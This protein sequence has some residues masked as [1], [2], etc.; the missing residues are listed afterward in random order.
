MLPVQQGVAEVTALHGHSE[1]EADGKS[2]IE[3]PQSLS[4]KRN[5]LVGI[6]ASFGPEMTLVLSAYAI[7]KN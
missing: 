3:C 2:I 6:H 5:K 4:R 1:T 7:G